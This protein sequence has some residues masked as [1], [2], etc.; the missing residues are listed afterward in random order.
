[1]NLPSSYLISIFIDY[2]NE[3]Q[4]TEFYLIGNLHSGAPSILAC[5][6]CANMSKKR[7]MHLDAEILPSYSLQCLRS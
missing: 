5:N 6:D 1:M 4:E 3:V 7:S 2:R